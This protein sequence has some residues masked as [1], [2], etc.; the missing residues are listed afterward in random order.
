MQ[1][2]SKNERGGYELVSSDGMQKN[3]NSEIEVL[4][5]KKNHDLLDDGEKKA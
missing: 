2:L 1:R 3:E 5:I 4:D